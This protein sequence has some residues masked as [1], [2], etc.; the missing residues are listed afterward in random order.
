ML[1]EIRKMKP[2]EKAVIFSEWTS[3]LTIYQATLER[4]GY[5][6][7]RIDGS[8]ST[9]QRLE[10]MQDFESNDPDSPKIIMCSIMACGTGIS[11]TRGNLAIILEPWWNYA[12]ESQAMDRV[13]RCT[14]S[15]DLLVVASREF[16]ISLFLLIYQSFQLQIHRIGQTRPVR[17]VRLIM[18]DSIESRM[19][20]KVQEAKAAVGK[21]SMQKLKREDRNKAKITALKD[22]FE[23]GGDV[24]WEGVYADENEDDEGDDLNGFIVGDDEFN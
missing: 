20:E 1:D 7:T 5:T 22:L 11:L 3:V 24:E 10:A 15:F 9:D 4:N 23:V 8:M 19:L 21:G 14:H 17:V 6:T 13:R 12:V 16:P 18:H 2:D